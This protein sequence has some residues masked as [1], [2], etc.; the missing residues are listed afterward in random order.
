MNISIVIC[1]YNSEKKLPDTLRHLSNCINQYEH[2]IEV[3]LIDNNSS[4]NTNRIVKEIWNT[5]NCTSSINIIFEENAGLANARYSGALNAKYDIILYC[6]DDNWLQPNY[7]HNLC[8]LFQDPTIGAIG[9]R[10][11]PISDTPI[12]DWFF[13]NMDAY[14][15]SEQNTQSLYGASLAIRKKI[16]IDFYNTSESKMLLG[17]TGTNLESGEDNYLCEFIKSNN[18]K[19]HNDNTPFIH[20]MTCNR[21]EIN[22]LYKLSYSF[23]KATFIINRYKKRNHIR[24]ILLK[25]LKSI[26][27]IVFLKKHKKISFIRELYFLKGYINRY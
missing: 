18:Y 5:L 10:G 8:N 1:C 17:R 16:I 3:L 11:I 2:D 4:D 27:N 26:F 24:Y 9:G 25:S 21:L 14:A 20:Y 12:P 6:D 22:Y 13:E 7:L 23:G 19:L 15:C